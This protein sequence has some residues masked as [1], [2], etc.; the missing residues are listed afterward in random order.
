MN[1]NKNVPI[2]KEVLYN[3]NKIEKNDVLP[4]T[5]EQQDLFKS[6]VEK[7]VDGIGMGVLE[8]GIPYLTQRGV[9]KLCGINTARMTEMMEE[10]NNELETSRIIKLKEILLQNEYLEKNLYFVVSSENKRYYA[11]PEP[12]CMSFLEY[13]A[14]YS[15]NPSQ[16]ARNN[17]I[18]LAKKTFRDFVYISVNYSPEKKYLKEWKYF[19]DRVDLNF[20]V[21]PDGFFSAFREQ[22]GLTATLIRNKVIVNDKTIPD[23][24]VGQCWSPYWIKNNF[25]EKYGERKRYEHN[26][27]DYYPQSMSNPQ[28]P[29]SYPNEALAVFRKWF[30]D[31][32]IASKFPSYL[33]KKVGEQALSH[34]DFAKT[35]LA[36]NQNDIN[37]IKD[38][39]LTKQIQ[40]IVNNNPEFKKLMN[41]IVKSSK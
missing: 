1:N 12:V 34:F 4:N 19:L 5:A 31:E 13:F 28:D 9:A 3:K 36:V 21:V 16:D 6:A 33:L 14:F 2:T 30:Y 39:K 40:E 7:E 23:I 32:Y 8:N 25:N 35:I 15:K 11:Y 18:K 37:K 38:P 41:N 10:Y 24:S 29:W 26:Y 22:A 27:P 20:D 17:L